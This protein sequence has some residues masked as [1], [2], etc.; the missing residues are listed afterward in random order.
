M[1]CSFKFALFRR[2]S[3]GG[4]ADA[5][6]PIRLRVSWGGKRCDIRSGYVCAPAKWDAVNGCVRPGYKN[7]YKQTAAEINRALLKLATLAE[8]VLERL[9]ENVGGAAPSVAEFTAAFNDAAGRSKPSPKDSGSAFLDAFDRFVAEQSLSNNWTRA[10]LTKFGSVRRSLVDWGAAL[11][12]EKFDKDDFARWVN[13][14]QGEKGLAN[15]TA[16]KHVGFLRWFL[17]WAAAN[18]FY[19]GNAHEVFR[20][21][22]K[23][24]DC[25]EV[26]FLEWDELVHFLHF[27]FG[28]RPALEHVRDVFCFCCFTGLRYS[29]AAKLARV[30][31]HADAKPP[32]IS[33]VTKKTTD[34]LRIE[35][36][37]Y[38]LALLAKY[39]D[40]PLPRGL[41]LPVISNQKM[42]EALHE[43]AKV[44]GLDAPVRVVSY[45]GQLRR[46]CVVPKYTVLSTHAGR[47]TFVVTALRLGIPPA[48]VMEWTGHSDYK[49]MKP[50]IKIVDA[51]KAE[52]MALFNTFGGDTK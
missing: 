38:A 20:P 33:V 1:K 52:N 45:V 41:A 10:T 16:A 8:E 17:R 47:R 2:G 49:A 15:T 24:L 32:Y 21:R 18:G 37:D 5:E 35:L 14:L 22:F 30:D 28:A 19:K 26:I 39:A 44:A 36:N 31:V 51:A 4:D 23:G 43:A 34:R 3:A 46:E 7:Q 29:D 25:K 27:D 48:V 42:N 9:A 11:N 50:Y 12:L 40:A 13:F 6:L